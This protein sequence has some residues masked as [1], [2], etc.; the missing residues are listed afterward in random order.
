MDRRSVMTMMAI[1]LAVYG[2]YVASYVPPML[3]G[4]PMPVILA[5]FVGQAVVALLAALGVWRASAWAPPVVLLLGGLIVLTEI[6]EGFVLGLIPFD[7]ALGVS[8]AG[9]LVTFGIAVFVRRSRLVP[10]Y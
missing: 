3:V 6:V 9:I 1:G 8:F 2:L 10:G 5:C 4:R 7:R